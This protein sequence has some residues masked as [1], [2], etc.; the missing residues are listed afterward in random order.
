MISTVR[1]A[2][3]MVGFGLG[4]ARD[5]SIEPGDQMTSSHRFGSRR[6]VA[7]AAAVLLFSGLAAPADAAPGDVVQTAG[8]NS[9]GQLGS[10]NTT[11]RPSFASVAGLANVDEVGG[12]REHALA[13]IGGQVYA[14][15]DG[16]RGATGQGN[17]ADRTTPGLVTGLSTVTQIATAHYGSYA[18]LADGTVRSWGYNSSGQLGDGTT[19]TR[20]RPVTVLGLSSV[21]QIA[22]GRDMAMA[23]RSDGRVWTW[24]LNTSGELGNG[25]TSTR[26]P[27]PALVPGLT[28]VTSLAGGRNH[29]LAVMADGTVRAWGQNTYGQ[30][31]TGTTSASQT[32]PIT[33]AGIS[34]A[35]AVRAGA[36]FSVALLADGRVMTWGRN[37][38]GQLASGNKINRSSPGFVAG[39]SGITSIGCGRGHG[40]AIGAGGQL[41]G[42]GLDNFGQLGDRVGTPRLTATLIPGV[43]GVKEAHAGYAYSV[44]RRGT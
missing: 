10:G 34:N 15:G 30:V 12:G 22:A 1:S 44:I 21:T 29:V 6:W 17:L 25:T 36:E 26:Q 37:N 32:S 4:C 24:G 28:G 35:V 23:L 11:N 14:W 8:L 2:G 40:L 19:T 18:L 39:L 27:T 43:T 7:L 13:R 20:T 42:W 31:G 9:D 33:V 16:S 38:N 41:Y 3:T 5:N